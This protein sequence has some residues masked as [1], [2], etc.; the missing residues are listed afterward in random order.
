[1]HLFRNSRGIAIWNKQIMM[2][3]RQEQKRGKEEAGRGH[4]EEFSV[5]TASYWLG[6]CWAKGSLHTFFWGM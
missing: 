2:D 3:H 1:M 4:F 5:V 6:C